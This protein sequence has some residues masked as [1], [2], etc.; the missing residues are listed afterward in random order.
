MA[1]PYDKAT[2]NEAHKEVVRANKLE[3]CYLRP[4]AFYGSEKMGVS[5][6]GTKVH[7]AD[8]RLALGRLPRRGRP[9]ARH[10]RQDLAATPATTSTSSMTRAKASGNYTNSILAN[11]EV[12]DDG[13]DEAMLLD[14]D[15]Y[16]RRRRRREPVHRQERRALHAGPV[17]RALNGITRATVLQI[18]ED[19]G[20]YGAWKSASPATRSTCCDEAFFTGTA[21][22]VTP[23]RELDGRQ[24]GIGRRGPI[25]AKIQAKFF[26]V[27]NG[28]SAQH[29]SWL[30]YV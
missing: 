7:V 12:T 15:G 9:G 14:P 4:I 24:I 11:M 17:L 27:V 2:I 8:R 21:A 29:E 26:D 30:A 20:L 6:K 18:A 1:M 25:T 5:P 10:P 28:R 19:L 23:I 3:A 16:R 13:Y 22:E